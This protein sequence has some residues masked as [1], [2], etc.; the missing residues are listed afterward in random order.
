MGIQLNLNIA[1]SLADKLQMLCA[2]KEIVF[3]LRNQVGITGQLEHARWQVKR[4]RDLRG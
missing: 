2:A 4:C 1:I 3:R